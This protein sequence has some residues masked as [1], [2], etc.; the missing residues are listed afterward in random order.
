MELGGKSPVIIFEDADINVAAQNA[1]AF[2]SLNG[3]GCV[4]GTRI[5]VQE[6]IADQFIA[7]FKNMVE[8]FSQTLGNDPH[9]ISAMSSPLFNHRQKEVVMKF[10]EIG[11]RDATLLTGG[12][13]WGEKGC[14]VQPTVFTKPDRNS[15][16]V[17]QEI[18]GPVVVVDTFKTEEEVLRLANDTEYGL[19]ATLYTNDIS[20]ALRCSLALEAGSVGVNTAQ[21]VHQSLPFG[22]W[23]GTS[24]PKPCS[25]LSYGLMATVASGIGSENAKYALRSYTQPK[26]ITIK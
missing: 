6:S 11:K 14:W 13:S 3:Q 8:G 1:M 4:L 18:F 2:V 15:D 22:G 25:H 23:K 16:I 10:L 9:D 21:L 12:N 20:R 24:P 19:G 7:L 5:Y 17:K 26:S